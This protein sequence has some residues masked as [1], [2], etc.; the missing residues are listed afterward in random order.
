LGRDCHV[1][2]EAGEQLRC[3]MHGI[4]YDPITGLCQSEICAGRS[5]TPVRVDEQGGFIHLVDKR[6]RLD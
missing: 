2:D 6:C 4:T 5:L 3:T 1:F